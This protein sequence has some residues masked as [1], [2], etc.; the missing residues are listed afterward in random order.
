LSEFRRDYPAVRLVIHGDHCPELPGRLLEGEIDLAFILDDAVRLPGFTVEELAREELTIVLRPDHPL[1]MTVP[2]PLS[3]FREESFMVYQQGHACRLALDAAFGQPGMRAQTT[4]EFNSD[5]AIKQ[6]V[7]AGIG[8]GV[9]PRMTV[10]HELAEGS[11]VAVTVTDFS[12]ALATQMVWHK[13][14]WLSPAL[15]VF[16][17]VSRRAIRSPLQASALPSA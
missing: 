3:A 5:E 11:L 7:L 15:R 4:L 16:A 8:V 17:D 6:C 2:V 1:A 14:K 9:V 12:I 10:R 13:D